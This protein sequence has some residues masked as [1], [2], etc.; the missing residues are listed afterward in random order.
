MYFK[1]FEFLLKKK[2]FFQTNNKNCKI[3]KISFKIY[4]NDEI[5]KNIPILNLIFVFSFPFIS[6][7]NFR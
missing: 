2:Y 3:A 4:F 5:A 1:I 7:L 6:F